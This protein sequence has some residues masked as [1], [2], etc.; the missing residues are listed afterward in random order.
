MNVRI[1]HVDLTAFFVSVE[2]LLNPRW[3]GQPIMVAGPPESRGVV[4][5]A[6]YEVRPYGVHAGMATSIAM[7]K[8]PIAI[9]I[10]GHYEAY[11]E[12]S[13]KVQEFLQYYSPVFEP[14][15]IDE[16]YMDWTGC[17]KIFGGSYLKFAQRLQR[18]IGR[19]FGLPCA[20]GIAS[21]KTLA[22]IACD[23]AK[24]DGVIEVP[25]GEEAKFLQPL[26][27]GVIPGVGD[28]M[29]EK[30]H[31]LGIRTCGQ[32][33]L[34]DAADVEHTLGTWGVSAQRHARGHG[35]DYLSVEHDQKQVSTEET[36][37]SDTR[38]IDFLHQTL[39]RMAWEIA[40]D[41]R[42]KEAKSRCIHLKLRYADWT[43]ITRQIAV[44]PTFDPVQIYHVALALLKR[45]DTR[46]LPVRLI[47][48][49]ASHLTNESMTMDLFHQDT[50]KREELLKTVD[51]INSKFGDSSL[52]RVGCGI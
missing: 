14:A 48:V 40:N 28:V 38:D 34:L 30:L 18:A 11:Q 2:R 33:A 32:L 21:N 22:K 7:R 6:S 13:R 42:S 5:C 9:R 10:D 35:S 41:L 15:S 51:R 29:L 36:F 31:R 37:A 16:F 24:P 12:F 8:C 25:D 46:R 47:G 50:E 17:G 52:I 3:V 19:R 44:E 43:T 45:A 23:R 49:G 27:V 39:H 20:M 1:A 26:D 4:T